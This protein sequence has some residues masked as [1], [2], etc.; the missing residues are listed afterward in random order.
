MKQLLSATT[1][2]VMAL[3]TVFM[4]LRGA[5]AQTANRQFAGSSWTLVSGTV[6]RGGRKVRLIV[7]RLQGFLMFDANNHFLMV[8]TH[9]GHSRFGSKTVGNKPHGEVTPTGSGALLASEGTRSTSLTIPS[10]RISM[11]ARSL[12]GS[13][14]SRNVNTLLMVWSDSL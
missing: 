2:L 9:F 8:I 11:R 1:A 12:N 4:P 3:L 10:A 13:E 14:P 6:D 7:P 5:V